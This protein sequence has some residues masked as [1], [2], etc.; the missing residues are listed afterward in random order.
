[1]SIPKSLF[2]LVA[3]SAFL[4]APSLLQGA[5]TP[6]FTEDL[7][8]FDV[9]IETD[10]PPFH[11]NTVVPPV[12]VFND[13]NALLMYDY[14][15]DDKP[16][17]QGELA[18]ALLS[19]FRIDFQ[20]YNQSTNDTSNAIRFRM[21]NLGDSISSESRSAFSVSWQADG[22]LTAKYQGIADG[23]PGDVDTLSSDPLV[24]VHDI[25]MIANGAISGNFYYGLFG[26]TRS[27]QPLSY[28]VYIDG[29]LLNDSADPDFAN[30]MK[31]TLLYSQATYDPTLGLQ[32]HGLLGN[33]DSA[34]DPDYLFDNIILRT[35]ADMGVIP[36]PTSAALLLI[37][38]LA[39]GRSLNGR[40]A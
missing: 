15:T 29:V 30:G 13:G 3:T 39:L 21:A 26:E 18:S 35:G 33:S 11:V 12:T 7:S 17:L 23:N 31:F 8:A 14:A 28:D 6:L 34:V 38:L 1:M 40:K 24:G 2:A 27:L 19:P 10:D 9:K 36:E 22:E 32:R 16:E 25:T 37:G 4:A 5:V 20:S